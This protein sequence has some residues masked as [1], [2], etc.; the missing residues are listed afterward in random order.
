MKGF[1][2]FESI[3]VTAE[4]EKLSGKTRKEDASI[5]GT[6]SWYAFMDHVNLLVFVALGVNRQ[7]SLVQ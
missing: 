4:K 7:S 2:L 6:H 3:T 5:L 1:K